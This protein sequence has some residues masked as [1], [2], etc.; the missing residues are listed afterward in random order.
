MASTL[1]LC[2]GNASSNPTDVY[3]LLKQCDSSGEIDEFE[4]GVCPF[5]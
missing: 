5:K 2:I 4:A 1:A 3:Q